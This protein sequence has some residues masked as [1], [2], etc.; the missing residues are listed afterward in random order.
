MNNRKFVQKIILPAISNIFKLFINRMATIIV[1]PQRLRGGKI[2]DNY[3]THLH[4]QHTGIFEQLDISFNNRFNFIV[5]PNG[6][7][8]T[9]ILKCIALALAPSSSRGFRY[10]DKS[11][12]WFDATYNNLNYRIGLGEGWVSNVDE[13]RN[14]IHQSWTNPP[15][16]E[17]IISYTVIDLERKSLNITP[18]ILG[19]YRRIEYKR[20]DGMHREQSVTEQRNIYHSDGF[21]N[22]EGGA[23]PDIKQWMINRYFEIE[24]E[25][26]TVYKQNWEWIIN[27][28]E[29][30]GPSN[31]KLEFK[32]IKRDLEPM[33]TLQGIDCYLEEVSAGFQAV[34]SLVFAIVEWIEGTN[35]EAHAYIPNATGTVIIDELDVHLHPEWQLTIRKSLATLFPKLQFIITTH[36]PH[37]ITSAEEG[38]LIVL[39]KLSRN[40]CVKPTAQ[41]YSGWNT[42]EVLEEIMGVSNLENKEYAILLN[43]AMDY[44]EARNVNALKESISKLENIVHPSNTIL[45][46]MR[47]KLAQLELGDKND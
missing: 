1:E 40:V 38:E 39:P 32:N 46:V 23:L 12:V 24:K 25:W 44:V 42:D 36:S 4:A 19:A 22:I 20:I 30:L 21:K 2:M 11:A 14:A 31:C 35:D 27:N 43:Q 47:I 7:G 45:H 18:L 41:K 8:K 29:N 37:L 9:S 28:L 34:L 15:Q 26:A 5:G 3:I 16:E 10:R 17:G 6:C 13:Y 33:F